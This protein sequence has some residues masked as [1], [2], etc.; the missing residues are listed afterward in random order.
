[1]LSA[2][3]PAFALSFGDTLLVIEASAGKACALSPV[4]CALYPVP[5]A[6][7]YLP[8]RVVDC[9]FNKGKKKSMN[10]P[11]RSGIKFC[12]YMIISSPD[13]PSLKRRGKLRSTFTSNISH[14]TSHISH[15]TSHISYLTS[16][17]SHL[18]SHISYLTSHISHLISHISH[19]ISHISHLTSPCSLLFALS[20]EPCALCPVP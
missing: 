2:L 15:L 11:P 1:M 13:H 10:Q 9:L 8:A 3:R 4:P 6:L 19:L 14:L 18:T 16:H 20:P 17:I 12:I 7:I 5:G